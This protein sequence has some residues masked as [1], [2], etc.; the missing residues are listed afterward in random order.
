MKLPCIAFQLPPFSRHRRR[1]GRSIYRADTLPFGSLEIKTKHDLSR[2][3]TLYLVHPWLDTL[4]E[5]EDR[6]NVTAEGASMS[7]PSPSVDDEETSDNEVTDDDE[8]VDEEDEELDDDAPLPQPQLSSQTAHPLDREMRAQR[9]VA[10]LRQP[11]CSRWIRRA[12]ARWTTSG[13]WL[14]A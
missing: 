5:R 10:H 12:Y 14:I 2:M 1:S 7:L 4:L 8:I 6:R 3:Q 13:S 11:S 9:L